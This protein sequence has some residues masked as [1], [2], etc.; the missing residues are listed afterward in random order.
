MKSLSSRLK[1]AFSSA[2]ILLAGARPS[3]TPGSAHPARCPEPLPW[4][5]A[6]A[7][8]GQGEDAADDVGEIFSCLAA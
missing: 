3:V 6:A 2:A 5:R 1:S 7:G 4:V 8:F